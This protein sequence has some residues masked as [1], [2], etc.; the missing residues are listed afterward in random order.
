M[1]F[2]DLNLSPA[3][4]DALADLALTEPTP[5]QQKA[6]SVILSGRDVVG[7]AQT[8]TGKTFAYLLPILRNLKFSKEKEPRVLILV[9]TRELVVQVVGEIEKLTRY[10]TV[11]VEGVFGGV[12]INTQKIAV[13]PGLDMLV[14]TPG[15][16]LDLALG[17]YINLKYVRQFVI[18]EVDEML[19]LGFRTQLNNLLDLL[20][21]KKQS[22]LFSATMTEEV[23]EMIQ[24]HFRAPILLEVTRAGTPLERIEQVAYPVPNFFTKLALL[25]HL[26]ATDETMRKVLIFGPSK[27]HADMIFQH[28]GN[29]FPEQF[30]IIH[31][32]KS[33][34]Y[35]LGAVQQFEEG[36]IRGLIATDILARGMDV[37]DV[38]HVI[39][40]DTPDE[41]ETYIHR[42]GRTGR[43]DRDG[44]AIL[45][46]AEYEQP[47]LEAIEALM[48]KEIPLLPLPDAVQVSA[49]LTE[50]ERY[51]GPEKNYLNLPSTRTGA[52]HEKL[53]KN[54]KVN[55][56]NKAKYMRDK[57]YKKPIKK[58]GKR[59]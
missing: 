46:V 2:Q 17:G 15:R 14:A 3:L 4:S 8:G 30:A 53:E 33:Q 39:S 37:Q 34:N 21:P 28:L 26:L 56:G 59:R 42:I 36:V 55:K 57:K 22:L 40:V 44:Q 11:R 27:R 29:Q 13:A 5:I 10:M 50:E 48:E 19:N 12:N 35:R 41:A 25:E 7:I 49:Q 32:N 58:G 47:A 51:S 16:L 52:F 43:A 20:P 6:F 1:S 24:T 54:K 45:F 38:T 9:P 23:D 18:D 31:S